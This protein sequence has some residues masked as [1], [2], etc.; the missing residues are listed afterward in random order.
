MASTSYCPDCGS[1][2]IEPWHK[3]N[4]CLDC[5][6]IFIKPVVIEDSVKLTATE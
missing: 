4:K 1:T 6:S 3:F 5:G 2:N